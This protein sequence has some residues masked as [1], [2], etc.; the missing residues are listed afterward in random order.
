MQTLTQNKMKNWKVKNNKSG[1]I[2]VM[3]EKVFQNLSENKRH[4]MDSGEKVKTGAGTD[5][6]PFVITD[7][8]IM[9]SPFEKIEEVDQNGMD[10]SE[11]AEH[12]ALVDAEAKAKKK[13][14]K[15]K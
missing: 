5:E 12:K 4:F 2:T 6:D 15:K 7:E 3:T 14:L 9:V 11:A 8:P 13:L 1:R 10:A